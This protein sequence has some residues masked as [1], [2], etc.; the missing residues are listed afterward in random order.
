MI[1]YSWNP[2]K[3]FSIPLSILDYLFI[4]AHSM[5]ITTRIN[6]YIYIYIYRE[7]ER[8]RESNAAVKYPG[9]PPPPVIFWTWQMARC[10][11]TWPPAAVSVAFLKEGILLK[12]IDSLQLNLF[13]HGDV[14]ECSLSLL[15][16]FSG[17]VSICNSDIF[18]H[19]DLIQLI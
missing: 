3:I 11:E 17:R 14:L 18:S 5:I 16:P 1:I 15:F 4:Y 19:S 10:T 13:L 2:L 7:R 6:I 12:S 9:V 8:E